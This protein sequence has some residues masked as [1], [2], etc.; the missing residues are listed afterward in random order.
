MFYHNQQKSEELHLF[1]VKMKTAGVSRGGDS[2]DQKC[3]RGKSNTSQYFCSSSSREEKPV[4]G[5]TINWSQSF[6]NSKWLNIT[7]QVTIKHQVLIPVIGLRHRI[8]I[9]PNKNTQLRQ[10]S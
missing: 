4:S 2:L 1:K 5:T 10:C 8:V 3:F 9:P 6:Y 7:V